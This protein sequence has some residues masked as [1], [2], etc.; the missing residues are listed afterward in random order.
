[1]AERVDCGSQTDTGE[2]DT[3]D[4]LVDCEGVAVS[5]A[6]VPDVDGDGVSKPSDCN[7]ENPAI[8]PGAVDVPE[9]GIDE[10]CSGADAVNLDRDAD[11]FLRPSDCNDNDPR[12][13]PGAV[14]IPGNRIDEDCRGGPAPFPLLDST[15]AATYTFSR[16]FTRF[17]GLTIRRVHA[18]ST[19]R[20]A[21]SG[22]GCPFRSRAR[23][24]KRNQRTL[25]LSRP[26]GGARLRPGAR[27]EVRVTRPGTVGVVARYTVRAGKAPARSD[28]CLSPGAKRPARC[29]V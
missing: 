11:G 19:L 7:D 8:H 21:C 6:L 27:F 17:T 28:R 20:M 3:I 25:A 5:S 26:L 9:N 1:L 4:L 18:G 2:A 23:K 16:S 10:D 12:I 15:I 22:R 14:D 24:L 13:H 29:P